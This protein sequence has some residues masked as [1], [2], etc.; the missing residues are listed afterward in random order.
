MVWV[1]TL[2]VAVI[3]FADAQRGG[4]PRFGF[5]TLLRASIPAYIVMRVGAE[6]AASKEH[7]GDSKDAWVGI[8]YLVSD[9]GVLLLVVA[10]ICAGV[11]AKRARGA[12]D[13]SGTGLVTTA[14][15]LSSLVLVG[16]L[17]AVWA[18]TTKPL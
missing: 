13:G 3:A 6:W 4:E 10:T 2:L 12:E 8:G 7:L 11:A 14:L 17:V 16:A 18:M 5:L 1:G 15:A 9:A